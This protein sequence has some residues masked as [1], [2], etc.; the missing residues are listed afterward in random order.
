MDGGYEN[1]DEY[2]HY[3]K[4]AAIKIFT[5]I[6]KYKLRKVRDVLDCDYPVDT[7]ITDT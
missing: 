4:K 2:S 5:W 1:L 6:K 3:V 7:E